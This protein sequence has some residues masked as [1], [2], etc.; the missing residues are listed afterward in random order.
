[1]S[2]NPALFCS[3]IR[4]IPLQKYNCKKS[5]C[6]EGQRSE[7]KEQ[8]RK[9]VRTTNSPNLETPHPPAPSTFAYIPNLPSFLSCSQ[10]PARPGRSSNNRAVR[11][12]IPLVKH[13]FRVRRARP[14]NLFVGQGGSAS[15]VPLDR[16]LLVLSIRF[17]LLLIDE[18]HSSP[19]Y[20][21]QN[22]TQKLTS[23]RPLT[24][25]TLH[26]LLLPQS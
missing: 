26:S 8:E 22:N 3:T 9:T 19:V 10:P 7:Q 4:Q 20:R 12:A 6:Q 21:D 1:M 23:Q 13:A 16:Y 25:Q 17:L 5:G 2:I 15:S 11:A 18:E 14:A 24:S